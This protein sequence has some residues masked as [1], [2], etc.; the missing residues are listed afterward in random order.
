M[1]RLR[2]AMRRLE[3]R[4]RLRSA[5]QPPPMVPLEKQPMMLSGASIEPPVRHGWWPNGEVGPAE[6]EMLAWVTPNV[7]VLSC[8]LA[9][10]PNPS[11]TTDPSRRLPQ[12]FPSALRRSLSL[13]AHFRTVHPST[14]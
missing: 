14:L 3:E 8:I 4:V 13:S 11:H 6:R 5:Q 10:T 12:G 1:V 9:S 2:V 7:P